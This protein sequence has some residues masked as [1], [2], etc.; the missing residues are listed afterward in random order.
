MEDNNFSEACEHVDCEPIPYFQQL[1]P[2]TRPISCKTTGDQSRALVAVMEAPPSSCLQ[3]SPAHLPELE[4]PSDSF[5]YYAVAGVDGN[6]P[7]PIATANN[8]TTPATP[9]S[10]LTSNNDIKN[11]TFAD[12]KVYYYYYYYYYNH[13]YYI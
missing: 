1:C 2:L 13:Y 6:V 4:P 7:L 11:S 3:S 5:A 9:A 10:Q 8:T 12:T